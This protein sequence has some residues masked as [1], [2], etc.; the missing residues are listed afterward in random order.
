MSKH[1]GILG[2]LILGLL[3][4]GPLAAGDK[5]APDNRG[6]IVGTFTDEDG[7][8]LVAAEIRIE[9]VGRKMKPVITR[10][11]SQGRY[12]VKGLPIGD[13]VVTACING[14]PAYRA[15]IRTSDKGYAK[16]DFDARLTDEGAAGTDRMQ[17]DLRFNSD[18]PFPGGR[19]GF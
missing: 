13:Y 6:A 14:S 19:N 2:A 5:K 10:T 3:I 16:V 9:A 8:K 12:F 15:R 1:F 17:R 18:S 11:D 4:T 7:K